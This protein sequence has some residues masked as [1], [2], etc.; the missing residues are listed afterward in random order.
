MPWLASPSSTTRAIGEAVEHAAERRIVEIGQRLGGRADQPGQ[1]WPTSPARPWT[2]RGSAI[3]TGTSSR[4]PCSPI[5]G[6][7]RD[8]AQLLLHESVVARARHAAQALLRRGV[9]ADRHH[10]PAAGRE[11]L[12][13]DVGH[14]AGRRPRRGSRRTARPPASRSVP[15]PTRTSMLS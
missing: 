5:S 7:K 11:L 1:V 13:Q 14:F 9:V 4:Q 3:V 8:A 2:R 12:Q 10:Q 6:T 15:S